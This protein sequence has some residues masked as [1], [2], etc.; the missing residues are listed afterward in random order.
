MSDLRKFAS[1]S[2]LIRFRLVD[3]T[4][5]QGKTGLTGSTTGL[6]ISTIA[7]NEAT[8][9]TYTQAAGHIQTIAVLGTFVAPSALNCRF[10]EVDSV[11]HKGLYEFQFADARFAVA[12]SKRLM[13]S[14]NDAENTILDAAY[15]IQ[16]VQFDPYD[17]VKLGLTCLPG[18]TIDNTYSLGQYIEL[19]GAFVGGATSGGP[20]APSFKN[21]DGSK[22]VAVGTADASG[23]RSG[24]T[25]TP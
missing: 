10:A 22:T 7:D 19:I 11:N 17:A 2:N 16:L 24:I 6:I 23:N 1:V 20:T 15:E 18:N 21:L 4:T 3:K 8:A 9:T 12:G 14:V 13:I 25:L 5:Q